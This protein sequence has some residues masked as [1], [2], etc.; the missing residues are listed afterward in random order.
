MKADCPSRKLKNISLVKTNSKYT[1]VVTSQFFTN[2]LL[3]KEV[4]GDRL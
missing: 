2:F 3:A 4:I 1:A